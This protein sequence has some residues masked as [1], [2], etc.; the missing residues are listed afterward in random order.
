MWSLRPEDFRLIC[1]SQPPLCEQE[2]I[3]QEL[4]GQLVRLDTA[5]TRLEHEITLLREYRTRLTSDVVT[6]K[7]DVRAA[8]ASLPEEAAPETDDEEALADETDLDT[9]ETEA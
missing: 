7:L 1:I 9:S 6:G 2:Q 3:A 5:I 4:G 8:A